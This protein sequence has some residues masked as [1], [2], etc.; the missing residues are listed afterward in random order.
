[1]KINVQPQ[2]LDPGC[3]NRSNGGISRDIVF[4][5]DYLDVFW[6]G[7][8]IDNADDAEREEIETELHNGTEEDPADAADSNQLL[9][10]ARP[11]ET[12]LITRLL[13]CAGSV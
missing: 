4:G 7:R 3:T 9:Y 12:S 1:M 5:V 2:S 13:G 6:N 10:A 11:R 8:S